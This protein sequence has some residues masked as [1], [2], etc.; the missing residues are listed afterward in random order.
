MSGI[1]THNLSG[2]R[3]WLHSLLEIQQPYDH[4]HDSPQDTKKMPWR[5]QARR[6]N[7]II[8]NCYES[9][10]FSKTGFCLYDISSKNF[11]MLWI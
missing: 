11:T 3:H 1:Q 4:D 2:D 5:L 8:N 9:I 7:I 6:T 10:E